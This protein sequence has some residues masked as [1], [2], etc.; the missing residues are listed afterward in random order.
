MVYVKCYM[1][2]NTTKYIAIFRC[3]IGKIEDVYYIVIWNLMSSKTYIKGG[4]IYRDIYIY[5][6]LYH[7]CLKRDVIET[8]SFRA[9]VKGI[10]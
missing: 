8:G 9:N 5:I 6:H 2:N 1:Y 3:A 10:E 4:I 7:S